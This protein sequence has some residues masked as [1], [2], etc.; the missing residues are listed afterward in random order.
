MGV[1]N[2]LHA[3]INLL[4]KI[5]AVKLYSNPVE[6][7][8]AASKAS[9]IIR[10]RNFLFCQS[11]MVRQKTDPNCCNKPGKNVAIDEAS[12][13]KKNQIAHHIAPSTSTRPLPA[14]ARRQSFLR[15]CAADGFAGTP[16]PPPPPRLNPFLPAVSPFFHKKHSTLFSPHIPRNQYHAPPIRAGDRACAG[17]GSQ[18]HALLELDLSRTAERGEHSSDRPSSAGGAHA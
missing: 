11:S 10:A 14:R 12:S 6:E 18:T 15:A 8:P 9:S 13:Q 3:C 16:C 7:R 2:I 17:R 5:S 1:L 4:P